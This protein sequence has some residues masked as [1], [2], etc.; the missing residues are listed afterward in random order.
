MSDDSTTSRT[1]LLAVA[2][3]WLLMLG[4]GVAI[5]SFWWQPRTEQVEQTRIQQERK[6]IYESTSSQSRFKHLVT[7]NLDSFSGYCGFRSSHFLEECGKQGIRIKLVDDGANYSNRLRALADGTCDLAVFTVDAL[8]KASAEL[9]DNPAT[10]VSIIDETKGADAILA[11]ETKFPD[12]DSLN[13]PDLN[14][15]CVPDSP[16]ETLARVIMAY[17][18][19]D[20]LAEDPFIYV[21][22]AEAVYRAYQSSKPSDDKV[23]VLWEPFVSRVTENPDYHVIVDSSKFRGYIVDVLVARR[24]FLHKNKEVVRQVV[25]NYQKMIFEN[26]NNIAE[27]IL[28][29][30]R[31]L[32]E[33]LKKEQAN[34]L[35]AG[36]WWKNTQ[37]NYAHFGL[38]SGHKLQHIEE[39]ITNIIDVLIKTKAIT[40]DPTGGSTNQL[41]YDGIMRELYGSQWHPGLDPE[42]I[43]SERSLTVLSEQEWKT[44]KPI[45][46]LQIPRLVFARGIARLRGHSTATLDKLAEN[47]ETW[48]QYYLTVIGSTTS[49]G[50]LEANRKLAKNRAQTA[51]NYLVQKGID[52]NRIH[53]E[54]NITN[55]STTVSFVLGELSY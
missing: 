15:V 26:R 46:T 19:L 53:A 37:E 9:G 5:W 41:Y 6:E 48:P 17:F 52:K 25:K 44:L 32:G 47:L 54:S 20:Q 29:D 55:G 31:Q 35:M 34:N 14:I 40:K 24:G 10:I 13:I 50:N 4:I 39:I 2:V 23:F 22:S 36:I 38:T 1:R 33:P 7:L 28:E 45:G 42:G 51:V 18:N 30:A 12:I 21:D 16:S 3:I 43:R 49:K 8:I 11:P 27:M